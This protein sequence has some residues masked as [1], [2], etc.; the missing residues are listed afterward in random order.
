VKKKELT[1]SLVIK[2]PTEASVSSAKTRVDVIVASA[3]SS[4]PYSHFVSSSSSFFFFNFFF[5]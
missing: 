1:S 2:G 4:V 5:F 3:M